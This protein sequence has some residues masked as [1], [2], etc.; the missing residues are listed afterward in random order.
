MPNVF[1]VWK[2]TKITYKKEIY[3][4]TK[5]ILVFLALNKYT[6]HEEFSIE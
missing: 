5:F 3:Y 1:D 4:F 6:N 2:E